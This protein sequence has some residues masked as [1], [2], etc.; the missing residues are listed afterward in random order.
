MGAEGQRTKILKLQVFQTWVGCI[1]GAAAILGGVAAVAQGWLG[2]PDKVN[3]IEQA[4]KP[5]SAITNRV[6]H[7]E[8]TTRLIW[9]KMNGD[10][11]LLIKI[12]QKMTDQ[13]EQTKELRQD[14]KDIKRTNQ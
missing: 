6:D 2:L 14:V 5:I 4:Q 13:A 10:H 7:L 1:A 12:D 8:D 11:D 3:A 9:Q